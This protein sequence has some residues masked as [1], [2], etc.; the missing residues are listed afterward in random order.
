[1]TIAV[2]GWRSYGTRSS[3]SKRSNRVATN[4][5]LPRRCSTLRHE[6]GSKLR[7]SLSAEADA[8]TKIGNTHRIRHSETSQEP[9]ETTAQIDYLFTRLFAFVY[10]ILKASN[11]AA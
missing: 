6:P 5:S 9:L 3:A 4:T 7:A 10:F 11:R 8:L 1:M 2:T